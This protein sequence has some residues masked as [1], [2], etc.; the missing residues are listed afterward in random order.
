MPP[1]SRGGGTIPQYVV[2]TLVGVL[3]WGLDAQQS[4]AL[5]D[6]GV[7]NSPTINIDGEHPD[8]DASNNGVH[9]SYRARRCMPPGDADHESIA[10]IVKQCESI[11]SICNR[12]NSPRN[13]MVLDVGAATLAP[14]AARRGKACDKPHEG[15]PQQQRLW[16]E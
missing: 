15:G 4:A 6:F 13:S 12:S 3:D 2:K 11:V 16:G 8:V 5:V 10:M 1:L 14:P 7:S 9:A